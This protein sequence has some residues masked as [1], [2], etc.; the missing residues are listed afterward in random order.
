MFS[1]YDFA[2]FWIPI[3]LK[4]LCKIARFDFI[5]K[6]INFIYHRWTH[7]SCHDTDKHKGEVF[8]EEETGHNNHA[9]YRKSAMRSFKMQIPF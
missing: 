5:T 6:N 3:P 1:M 9:V 2:I 7:E 4:P 8:V